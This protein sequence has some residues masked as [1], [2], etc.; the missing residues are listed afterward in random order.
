[1]IFRPA[2]RDSRPAADALIAQYDSIGWAGSMNLEP[3]SCGGTSW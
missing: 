2:A 1:M 3:D